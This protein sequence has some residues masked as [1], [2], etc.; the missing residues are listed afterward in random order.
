M[1]VVTVDQKGSRSRGDA[2]PALLDAVAAWRSGQDVDPFVLPLQRTADGRLG[3]ALAD[4]GRGSMQIVFNV[5]TPD[6]ASFRKSEAQIA[7]MLA[8]A[9]SR[10]TRTL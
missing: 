5:S 3:V 8:R 1:F 4:G 6:A 10:G 9:V 2:V 7:G